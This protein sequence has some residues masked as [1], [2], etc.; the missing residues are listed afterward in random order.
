MKKCG[1][2]CSACPYIKEGQNIKINKNSDWKINKEVSCTSY[3][4]VYMIECNKDACKMRYIGETQRW[5]R[6]R[7]ADHRG[8]V[9]NENTNTATGAHFCQPGHSLS[10]MKFTILEQVKKV[11]EIYGKLFLA[12][13]ENQ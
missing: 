4:V 5:L 6:A 11:D 1:Q 13:H 3:N 10:D 2:N 12:L 9:R 7:M 8:Y